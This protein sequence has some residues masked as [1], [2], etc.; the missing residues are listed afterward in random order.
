MPTS[1]LRTPSYA[2]VGGRVAI[3]VTGGADV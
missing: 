1:T 2:I 3:L